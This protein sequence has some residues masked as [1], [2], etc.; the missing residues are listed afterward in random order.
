M[1]KDSKEGILNSSNREQEYHISKDKPSKDDEKVTSF[2]SN[3]EK[4]TKL[5]LT[6]EK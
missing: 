4:D 3:N 5:D 2:Y 6:K 1:R